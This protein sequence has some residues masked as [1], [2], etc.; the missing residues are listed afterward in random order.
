MLNIRKYITKPWSEY[1][2]ILLSK[3]GRLSAFPFRFGLSSL[4][5]IYIAHHPYPHFK[6][7]QHPEFR[8]LLSKFKK[9]NARNSGDIPRLWSFILNIK[10]VLAEKVVGDFAEVGVWRG[11]TAAV[12]AY[13]AQLEERTLYLFDTYT[14]FDERD[15]KGVDNGKCRDFDNTSVSLVKEVV[16][17]DCSQCQYVKGFFP[18]SVTEEHRRKKYAVRP[19]LHPLRL[20]RTAPA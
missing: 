20:G 9:H 4:P 18:D 14:G 10:Q 19:P 2:R 11:N 1:K 13:Y 16:G 8:D 7:G 3:L 6:H 12:L 5:Y 15:L 17:A